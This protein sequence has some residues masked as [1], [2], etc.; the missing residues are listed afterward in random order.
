MRDNQKLSKRLSKGFKRLVYWNEYNTKTENK[1]M[2]N[3]YR[4]LLEPNFVEVNRLFVL[5]CTNKDENAKRFKTG[6]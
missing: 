2:T 1:N 6:R 5:V 3:E 4:Y